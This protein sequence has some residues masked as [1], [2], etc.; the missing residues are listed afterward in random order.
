MGLR[1]WCRG[2]SSKVHNSLFSRMIWE[3]VINY[4]IERKHLT[5]RCA[6]RRDNCLGKLTKV[7]GGPWY[8]TIYIMLIMLFHQTKWNFTLLTRSWRKKTW[9][10]NSLR[11][12]KIAVKC[13]QISKSFLISTRNSSEHQYCIKHNTFSPQSCLNLLEFSSRQ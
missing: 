7:F 12:A 5:L 9:W 6:L 13:F 11:P 4:L 10:T 1:E 8:E 2:I 3:L